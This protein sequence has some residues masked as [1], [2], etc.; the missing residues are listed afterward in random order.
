MVIID[1]SGN[2]R[3]LDHPNADD[4]DIALD[5]LIIQNGAPLPSEVKG[6][7]IRAVLAGSLTLIDCV[8][9]DNAVTSSLAT[10]LKGGG[11]YSNST[12]IHLLRSAV[13]DNAINAS[14][15]NAVG[16]GIYLQDSG[17]LTIEDSRISGNSLIADGAVHGGGIVPTA[18]GDLILRRSEVANNQVTSHNAN[19]FAGGI[20]KSG[21]LD[22]FL[23]NSTVSGNIVTANVTGTT[24]SHGALY[25]VGHSSLKVANSSIVN[26][27]T[28]A[29]DGTAQYSG[30]RADAALNGNTLANTIIANNT[31]NG[32]PSDCNGAITSQGYNLVE[33]NCGITAATGDQF[34]MDPMLGP[35]ADHGGVNTVAQNQRTHLPQPGSPVID[36][37][38]P[39]A[40][41][42]FPNCESLD[43][44]SYS[45]PANGGT[46]TSCDI[47]AHE[48]QPPVA[49]CIFAHNYVDVSHAT[50][51]LDTNYEACIGITLGPQVDIAAGT[52]VEARAGQRVGLR[53][54]VGVAHNAT[55]AV[56]AEPSSCSQDT[57]GDGT[58]DCNDIRVND[59]DKVNPG[60][61]GC[62]VP[63]TD[64]D[65]IADCVDYEGTPCTVVAFS[66]PVL[67]AEIRAEYGWAPTQTITPAMAEAQ[68]QFHAP[69]TGITGLQ[70]LHCFINLQIVNLNDNAIADTTPLGN[71][72]ALQG[73]GVGFNNVNDITALGTLPNLYQVNLDIN[74]ITSIAP[75]LSILPSAGG[76]LSFVSVTDNPLICDSATISALEAEIGI[77]R[78]CP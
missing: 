56:V 35:L 60:Q 67:E 26:N 63:D 58:A 18:D 73:L 47:G 57:D 29:P 51:A 74:Q 59:P 40:A 70:G 27:Q 72:K 2:D 50:V 69:N 75:L 10:T 22:F 48:V 14:A 62:G 41:T 66:D 4:A 7:G 61:C 8:V 28:I 25:V 46:S 45:R 33:T 1:G 54:E 52:D 55:L 9:R 37:G 65:G 6:G 77:N 36:A 43:Q 20:V 38:N 11:I 3:V 19:A 42:G 32:A 21:A 5:G 44:R 23:I 13:V 15:G 16:G 17:T 64:G 53:S 30:L 39:A 24:A 68:T 78:D 31:S 49:G 76:D 34:G 12:S 71:I